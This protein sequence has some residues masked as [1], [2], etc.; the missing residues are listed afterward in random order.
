MLR[1]PNEWEMSVK[2]ESE[3]I[4]HLGQLAK[5]DA[6]AERS[7][8]TN[9]VARP[10]VTQKFLDNLERAVQKS[11]GTDDYETKISSEDR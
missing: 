6:V 8:L 2:D 10:R 4:C 11:M 7:C 5:Q 1:M 9:C 3:M